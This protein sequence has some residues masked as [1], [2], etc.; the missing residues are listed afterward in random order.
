MRSAGAFKPANNVSSRDQVTRK[1][2]SCNMLWSPNW[3]KQI[4]MGF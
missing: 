2:E 3:R 4:V 1:N